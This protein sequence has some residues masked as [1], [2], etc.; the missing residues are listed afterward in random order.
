MDFQEPAMVLENARSCF[1]RKQNKGCKFICCPY[2]IDSI[3]LF[4]QQQTRLPQQMNCIPRNMHAL[5][6]VFKPSLGNSKFRT[7]MSQNRNL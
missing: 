1:V 2:T 4:R 5:N 6:T 7:R 3:L